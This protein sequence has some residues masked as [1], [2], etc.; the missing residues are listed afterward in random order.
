VVRRLSVADVGLRRLGDL[1]EAD[2]RDRILF[3]DRPAVDLLEEL[4]LV[5]EAAELGVVVLDVAPGEVFELLHLD[6]VNDRGEDFLARAVAEANR[7][8]DDL[9]A[10]VL[11]ALV[12]EPDRCRLAAPLQLVDENRR[13]KVE[14]V[15]ATS[16]ARRE[17]I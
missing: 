11:A 16:H 15:G 6:V 5:L 8:P 7:D 10:L 3:E 12:A 17:R 2:H 13:I 9:A 14:Y 1:R 4:A